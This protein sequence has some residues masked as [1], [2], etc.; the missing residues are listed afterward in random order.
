MKLGFLILAHADP[1]N[2]ARLVRL[3]LESDAAVCLHYDLKA[4]E[5]PLREIRERLGDLADRLILATR[6]R[7]SWGEWSIVEA[8]L[9]GL[10]AL[11]E[12]DRDLDYIH[13][14]SGS[15]YPIRPISEFR[16]FLARHAGVDFI[17]SH[18]IN[19]KRW[20][21]D[22]L[23]RERYQYR[24]F[25]NFKTH[26]RLFH[27]CWKTQS[28]LKIRR[29]PP[30]GLPIHMGSQWWTLTAATCRLVLARGTSKAMVRFFRHSWIPDEM[31]VQSLAAQTGHKH[32]NRHLTLYQFNDYGV[33]IVY[34]DSHAAYLSR[35]PFF[36]ARKLS[37]FAVK[38]RDALDRIICGEEKA[39]AFHDRDIGSPTGE[40]SDFMALRR[41][42]IA[43]LRIPGQV[44]AGK[45]GELAWNIRRYIVVAGTSTYE[46]QQ[47]AALL[48][49][50]P[51]LVCHGFLFAAHEVDFVEGASS[52]AGYSR[53]AIA[54]RDHAPAS[55]LSDIIRAKAGST[56]CFLL[57]WHEAQA[58]FNDVLRHDPHATLILLKGGVMRAYRDIHALTPHEPGGTRDEG[59][60]PEA[61]R[62]TAFQEEF[63]TFAESPPV[64][65]MQPAAAH[66]QI[67]VLDRNWPRRVVQAVLETGVEVRQAAMPL[68]WQ[69]AEAERPPVIDA[70]L[71]AE[72][73]SLDYNREWKRRILAEALAPPKNLYLVLVSNDPSAAAKLAAGLSMTGLFSYPEVQ[74]VTVPELLRDLVQYRV[75]QLKRPA[76]FVFAADDIS[77]LEAVSLDPDARILA[78]TFAEA[79]AP[80]ASSPA[81]QSVTEQNWAEALAN[82]RHAAAAVR[83]VDASVP[84]WTRDVAGFAARGFPVLAGALAQIE[85]QLAAAEREESAGDGLVKEQS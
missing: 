46:L 3:L 20:V 76:I 4:G 61:A 30:A 82:L 62:I 70:A 2:T 58:F 49:R 7:V 23:S 84:C 79:A 43:G 18:A 32:S 44:P 40:Y 14:M 63:L 35:Q 51:Q 15:D 1:A 69:A 36:F 33:P 85:Q 13:L 10:A 27:W 34:H 56:T 57:R 52:L 81:T 29:K 55:F 59:R 25:F 60:V 74:P 65:G 67:D 12:A 28:A 72:F 83:E 42:G 38:L 73:L 77:M 78:V 66:H 71:S 50:I 11:L 39:I 37:P 24:H 45:L 75:S 80:A 17:E 26:P 21:K 48:R 68:S 9:N 64:P 19:R 16:S 8:T 5:A 6:V 41:N 54:L 53:S 22:G 47:A 31:A